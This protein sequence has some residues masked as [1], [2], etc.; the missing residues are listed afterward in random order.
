MISKTNLCSALIL[1]SVA[2]AQAINTVAL[3]NYSSV[4][5]RYKVNL[6]S[7]NSTTLSTNMT[8]SVLSSGYLFEGNSQMQTVKV[9]LPANCGGENL[10]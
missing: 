2:S 4:P 3:D 1:A 6:Q 7:L 10:V 5:Y 9:T 8:K